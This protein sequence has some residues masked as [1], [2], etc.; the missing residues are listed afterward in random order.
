MIPG[1]GRCESGHATDTDIPVLIPPTISEFAMLFPSPMK[2][3]FFPSVVPLCSRTVWR[4]ARTW[5]GWQ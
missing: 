1:S 5:Q 2:Q 3:S 4:S